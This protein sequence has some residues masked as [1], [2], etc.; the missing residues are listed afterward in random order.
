MNHLSLSLSLSPPIDYQAGWIN[1][2]L[3][4]LYSTRVRVYCSKETISKDEAIAQPLLVSHY[5]TR[6]IIPLALP[7]SHPPDPVCVVLLFILKILG[8]DLIS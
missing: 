4:N 2:C 5:L 7:R 3:V 6:H 8:P 1:D